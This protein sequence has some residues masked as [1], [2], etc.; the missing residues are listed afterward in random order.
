MFAEPS[1]TKEDLKREAIIRHKQQIEKERKARIFNP[2]SRVIGVD[3][4]GLA[5]QLAE[6]QERRKHDHEQERNHALVDRKQHHLI[7]ERANETL[8][9]RRRREQEL[10]E[11]RKH[12]QYRRHATESEISDSAHGL[13]STDEGE[14]WRYN[15]LKF[16]GEDPH[17]AER[18]RHQR[19]QERDWLTQQ[20]REKSQR[21]HNEYEADE[22]ARHATNS[23][24]RRISYLDEAEQNARR[25]AYATTSDYNRSLAAEQRERRDNERRQEELANRAEVYNNLT[26]P[27]LN[28]SKDYAGSNFGGRRRNATM[29]KGMSDDEMAMFWKE[30]HLQLEKQRQMRAQEKDWDGHFDQTVE[31][32]NRMGLAQDRELKRQQQR[33]IIGDSQE[34]AHLAKD[35]KAKKQYMDEVEYTN[36]PTEDYFKQF[37]TTSR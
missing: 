33:K 5:R 24:H 9:D 37:N 3:C 4:H 2:R 16:E 15:S 29:Y 11:Y 6:K 28:E 36:R 12:H 26:S 27:M 22:G 10:N 14:P 23:M 32:F 30:K 17:Y 34:N 35:Q 18:T 21:R 19:A 31:G 7:N 1:P 25:K 13:S 20:I 8:R